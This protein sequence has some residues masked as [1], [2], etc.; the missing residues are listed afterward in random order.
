MNVEQKDAPKTSAKAAEVLPFNPILFKQRGRR[1][2]I[3]SPNAESVE[4]HL[5]KPGTNSVLINAIAKAFY[6]AHLIN[7]GVVKSGSEI[8]KKEGVEVSSVNELIRLT[9][10][11][12]SIVESILTG[13]QPAALNIQW[14]TRHPLPIDWSNQRALISG[15]T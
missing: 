14:F 15:V 2:T 9:L 10:L 4:T 11:D 1:K 5:I 12:P 7:N 6:W 8:A 13:T 3:I